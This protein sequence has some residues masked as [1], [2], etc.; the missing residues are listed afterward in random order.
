MKKK[1][2]KK[3][4]K[5]NPALIKHKRLDG[6][7]RKLHPLETSTHLQSIINYTLPNGE[8]AGALLLNTSR[9]L[10]KPEYK[11]RFLWECQGYHDDFGTVEAKSIVDSIAALSRELPIGESLRVEFDC[12]ANYE[13]RFEELADLF[14][15]APVN[16]QLLIAEE[17]KI[18]QELHRKGQRRPKKIILMATYTPQNQERDLDLTGKILKAVATSFQ[19]LSGAIHDIRQ[20]TIDLIMLDGYEQGFLRWQDLFREKLQLGVTAISGEEAWQFCRQELNRFTDSKLATEKE[21][22]PQLIEFNLATGT[23][24]ENIRNNRHPTTLM[25]R[26]PSAIPASGRDFVAVDGK[27][28]GS[29]F[30]KSQ[31]EA[32]QAANGKSFREIQLNYLWNLLGR[33]SAYD[34]KIILEISR[35]EDFGTRYNNQQLIREAH[36]RKKDKDKKGQIDV[37]AEI[38]LNQ[39]IEAEKKLVGGDPVVEFAL[40]M[41]VYRDSLEEMRLAARELSSYFQSPATMMLEA[42]TA[43]ALW[44]SSLPFYGRSMLVDVRDRRDRE[45]PALTAAY[46]PLV[47]TINSHNSGL[48]FIATKGGAPVYL[49]PW[50][51]IGHIAIWGKTRSGKSLLAAELTY[52]TLARQMPVTILD[53]PPSRDASTFKDFVERMDGSYVDVFSDSLNFLETP[54]IPLELDD[55]TRAD[56]KKQSEDFALQTLAT[57]VLGAK[58][59]LPGVSSSKVIALLTAAQ[60]RFYQDNQIKLRYQQARQGGIG[61]ESWKMYPTLGDFIQFCSIERINLKETTEQDVETLSAIKTQLQRW[62]DGPYGTTINS[63]SS[64]SL[65]RLLLAIAM[66]G[67][68]NND[69][70]AVFGSIMFAAAN[71]RAVASSDKNGSLLFIDEASIT[72]KLD[73]LSLFIA[74]TMANGLKALMRVAIAG[75]EPSSVFDSAGGKQ[76]KDA[77]SYHL[78]GRIGSES[79]EEYCDPRMLNLPRALAEN[80]AKAAFGPD[81]ATCSSQWLLKID[82]RFTAARIY[83]PPSLVRLTNNNFDKRQAREVEAAVAQG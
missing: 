31:P 83:L 82:D 56:L 72:F 1:K 12:F 80:N 53:Q 21:L 33:R 24:T 69:D 62:I 25:M 48:E 76:I 55:T 75:Q 36:Y 79:I 58:G 15:T 71:R 17:I 78:I 45:R 7:W 32:F 50:K 30:L 3:A 70:A 5:S 41:F 68:S 67:V 59:E 9:S 57:M 46:Y 20:Q 23:I 77:I 13:E 40:T 54:E 43:D 19:K 73:A 26:E 18:M 52:Q 35:P 81:K 34:V 4:D 44:L 8:E 2:L 38:E 6:K 51:N 29:M 60:K 37:A 61:S 16:T 64:V 42:D 11:L 28:I 27:Y 49:D 74:R 66:R 65:D 47:N 14:E 10:D 39:A 22:A 63:P